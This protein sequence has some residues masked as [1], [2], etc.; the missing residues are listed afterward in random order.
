MPAVID[1]EKCTK[2]QACVDVCPV[3]CIK[4]E[5]DTVPVIDANECI[6][7]GACETECPA[8]AITLE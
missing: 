2:C 1:P 6:D 4:G 5:A 7:C 3:E 8:D